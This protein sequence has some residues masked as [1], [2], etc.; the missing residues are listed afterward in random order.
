MIAI[1]IIICIYINQ[2]CE[3][4]FLI[5]YEWMTVVRI[6][7]VDIKMHLSIYNNKSKSTTNIST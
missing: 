4:E 6:Y 2:C 3:I 5:N 7:N 1:M